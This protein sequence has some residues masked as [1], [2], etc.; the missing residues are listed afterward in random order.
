M[1]CLTGFWL[2]RGGQ[3]LS[4]QL[5]MVPVIRDV[6]RPFI[7]KYHSHHHSPRQAIMWAGV[8]FEGELVCVGCLE[9][10]KARFTAV[11]QRVGEITRV[12][13]DGSQKNAASKCIAG[14]ARAAVALGYTRLVSYTLLGEAGTSYRAA[15]WWVT[16]VVPP[17]E[18]W[19]AT[20]RHRAP[21]TQPGSKVRW[22]FGPEAQPEDLE[23]TRVMQESVGRIDIPEKK[24]TLPLFTGRL[25]HV[26]EGR[27]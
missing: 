7:E 20:G 12:A 16:A 24:E 25:Q 6:A 8:E 19:A 18:S 4:S 1:R 26:D 22:E 23:A 15:G 10:P 21:A 3:G 13:S 5:R 14:L 27:R 11:D 2:S 9:R 17:R